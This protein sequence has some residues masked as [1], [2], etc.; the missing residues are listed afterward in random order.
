MR[1]KKS[2]GMPRSETKDA[3]LNKY[4]AGEIQIERSGDCYLL[5]LYL[6]LLPFFIYCIDLRVGWLFFLNGK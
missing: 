5:L 3:A 2:A 4:L 1:R 6:L